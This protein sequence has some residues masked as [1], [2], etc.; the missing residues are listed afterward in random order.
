MTPEQIESF[1]ESARRTEQTD[2]KAIRELFLNGGLHNTDFSFLIE[3]ESTFPELTPCCQYLRTFERRSELSPQDI[4]DLVKGDLDRLSEE[5]D[6]GPIQHFV[7]MGVTR[8]ITPDDGW[9]AR[10]TYNLLQRT[11]INQ[12][13]AD[14]AVNS[15]LDPYLCSSNVKRLFFDSLLSLDG[16]QRTQVTVGSTLFPKAPDFR[17]HRQLLVNGYKYLLSELGIWVINMADCLDAM[18]I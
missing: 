18:E 5:G 17:E 3:L 6:F 2:S 13:L 12:T 8:I 15:V 16:N 10:S 4:F 7:N 14:I 1:I 9:Q 11:L